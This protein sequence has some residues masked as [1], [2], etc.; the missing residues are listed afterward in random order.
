LELLGRLRDPFAAGARCARD[1]TFLEAALL[2]FK[3]CRF[4]VI[5]TPGSDLLRALGLT[6]VRAG[7]A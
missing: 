4:I 6:G 5:D 2:A 7:R 3:D 1:K